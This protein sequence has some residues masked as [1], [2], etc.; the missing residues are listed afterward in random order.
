MA[1][2]KPGKPRGQIP[3]PKCKAILLC[4]RIIIDALTGHYNAIGI[5][6]EFPVESFPG[7]S[8]FF[9][10]YLQLTGGIGT[11][12]ITLE[13]R[14]LEDNK[15]IAHAEGPAT[16]FPRR[17][18]KAHVIITSSPVRLGHAGPYDFV[19]LANG[20]E[21]DRQQFRAVSLDEENDDEQNEA[22]DPGK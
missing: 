4:D 9:T 13:V 5:F 15:L 21:I 11:Y 19:V 17:S 6:D 12:S 3:P 1:K 10:V 16:N 8:G 14:D 18:T 20:Q 22:E 2:K 7:Q